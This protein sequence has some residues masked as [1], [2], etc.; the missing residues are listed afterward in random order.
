MWVSIQ[1]FIEHSHGPLKTSRIVF[2]VPH[3][4]LLVY[5]CRVYVI[6]K[7]LIHIIFK[8]AQKILSNCSHLT[9]TCK[10]TKGCVWWQLDFCIF[11]ALLSNIYVENVFS[12]LNY[13]FYSSFPATWNKEVVSTPSQPTVWSFL[14]TNCFMDVE[15]LESWSCIFHLYLYL[16]LIL[17]ANKV[18]D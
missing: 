6:P 18:E 12:R 4:D 10:I 5:S 15:V 9:K 8:N 13:L 1:G 17:V 7:L 14:L 16:E 2:H 11:I 3:L